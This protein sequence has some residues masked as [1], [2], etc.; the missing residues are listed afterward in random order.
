MLMQIDE[1]RRDDQS[2][3]VD[4]LAALERPLADRADDAARDADGSD[5]IGVRLRIHD[6]AVGNHEIER[7]AGR[8][9]REQTGSG[10][11]RAAHDDE[12]SFHD[13]WSV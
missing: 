7:T 5:R 6:T 8:R 2:A 11:E 1:A 9:L 13:R 12:V 4:R 3:R 10:D